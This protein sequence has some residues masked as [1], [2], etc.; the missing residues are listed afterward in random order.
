M[1]LKLVSICLLLGL[2][3]SL[4]GGEFILSLSFFSA[5]KT[6][7]SKA[8]FKDYERFM[9]E[10]A[11]KPLHVK[12]DA[13]NFYINAFVGSYD[14]QTYQ[15]EDFW[16]TRV[17]FLSVGQGDCEDYVIAKYETLKDFGVDA[18]HMGLCIVKERSSPFHHMVLL[19]WK[20]AKN[21]PLVLD[22]L[23]FKV[24]PL[25]VRVDLSVEQCMNEEGYFK[26]DAKA[27]PQAFQSHY[28]I[29]AYERVKQQT[30]RE[31]LWQKP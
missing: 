3:G 21:Q 19:L 24:L 6:E 28:V 12:L 1:S 7:K 10:T 23:S 20:D 29:K 17:E 16:A 2:H 5:L 31:H 13:V 9:N 14:E 22:N 30:K 18:K 4:W 8:I 25:D 26:L 27:K 11:P 15:T